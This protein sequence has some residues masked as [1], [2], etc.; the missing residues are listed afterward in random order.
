MHFVG[1]DLILLGNEILIIWLMVADTQ[2]CDNIDIVEQCKS[3]Q[4]EE[5]GGITYV[6]HSADSAHW[7]PEI[8][9][10]ALK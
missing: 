6:S 2:F 4:E 3:T 7:R 10:D 9:L 5:W 8:I 1:K